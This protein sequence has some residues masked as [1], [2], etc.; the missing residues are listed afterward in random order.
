MSRMSDQVRAPEDKIPDDLPSNVPDFV[1]NDATKGH[2]KVNFEHMVVEDAYDDSWVIIYRRN[3]DELAVYQQD[4]LTNMIKSIHN[5]YTSVS[6]GT[7]RDGYFYV[8]LNY[9]P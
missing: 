5:G 9:D 4:D 7:D 8:R 6:T 1:K 3:A 2:D